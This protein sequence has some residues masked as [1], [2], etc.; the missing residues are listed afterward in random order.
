MIA[1]GRLS[2]REETDHPRAQWIE[3]RLVHSNAIEQREAVALNEVAILV[4]IAGVRVV[5]VLEVTAEALAVVVVS[6]VV[7]LGE[8]VA[9][10]K[11]IVG[12]F[13]G[14][15]TFPTR[16]SRRLVLGRCHAGRM[17]LGGCGA[18]LF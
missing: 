11:E 15:A 4:L 10:A 6:E 3:V 5:A 1:P 18:A 17:T 12:R 8:V 2:D 7:D 13:P 9:A 16:G 14:A